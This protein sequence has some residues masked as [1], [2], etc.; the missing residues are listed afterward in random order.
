MGMEKGEGADGEDVETD[1]EEVA[2]GEVV[3]ETG[4]GGAA[5]AERRERSFGKKTDGLGRTN[6]LSFFHNEWQVGISLKLPTSK[7][8]ESKFLPL[9]LYCRKS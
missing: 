7:A 1:L 3:A 5:G 6:E 9:D 8:G 4:E 2:A